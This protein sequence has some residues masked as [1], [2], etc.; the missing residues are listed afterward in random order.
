MFDGAKERRLSQTAMTYS[1]RLRILKCWIAFFLHFPHQ[2]ADGSH[3][4][5]PQ[6]A[7]WTNCR[8]PQSLRNLCRSTE[9]LSGSKSELTNV[10]KEH[11][12]LSKWNRTVAHN[13][14]MTYLCNIIISEWQVDTFIQWKNLNTN[15]ARRWPTSI[16][17][18][19][20]HQILKSLNPWII[21]SLNH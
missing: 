2:G 12:F 13:D 4:G 3:G 7:R 17:K 8:K 1:S 20:N 11:F 6:R 16:I 21:K 9:E 18:S 5:Q 10:N 14:T 19:L 15:V